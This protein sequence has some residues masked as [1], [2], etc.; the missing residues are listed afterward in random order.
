MDC[1]HALSQLSDRRSTDADKRQYAGYYES[2]LKLVRV[3][4]LIALDNVLWHGR[5][6]DSQVCNFSFAHCS[7]LCTNSTLG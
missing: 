5:V 2:C 7:R 3:G 6:A 1:E 4:G